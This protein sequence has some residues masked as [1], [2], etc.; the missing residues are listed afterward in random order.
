MEKSSITAPRDKD[1][2]EEN[3]DCIR[4]GK[5]YAYVIDGTNGITDKQ[6]TEEASNGRW[7]VKELD[8]KLSNRIENQEK[9]IEQILSDIISELFDEFEEKVREK[10]FE[11]KHSETPSAFISIARWNENEL[12][13]YSLGDCTALIKK[14]NDLERFRNSKMIELEKKTLEKMQSY[15]NQGLTHEQAVEKVLPEYLKVKRKQDTPGGWYSIGFNP[16]TPEKGK[17]K[18]YDL[19]NIEELLLHT[20]G[21][22]NLKALNNEI[23]DIKD[24][25]RY[26]KDK[27]LEQ[28]I[29]KMRELEEKDPECNQA[30]RYKKSDDVAVA[31]ITSFN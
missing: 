30:P 17:T 5:D 3:E 28:S 21:L 11:L 10:D 9:E 7:Y 1:K 31:R 14:E 4:T 22:E 15:K 6:T 25:Y 20:D 18:K 12:E 27:G 26:I 24:L 8:K 16:K 19:E 29:Q 2:P 13:L 23:E